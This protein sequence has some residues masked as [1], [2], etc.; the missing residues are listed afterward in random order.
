MFLFQ[1]PWIGMNYAPPVSNNE[2]QY[3]GYPPQPFYQPQYPQYA[4]W[5]SKA[6][7]QF[8]TIH[9][10][11]IKSE[12]LNLLNLPSVQPSQSISP[13]RSLNSNSM[14]SNVT[15]WQFLLEL[16]RNGDHPE[17]IQWTNNE[18][19]FK[20]IDAEAV[21]RLWGERKGKH[22]MN[23]DKLSRALRYY[24]D[25]NIIRKV[26]G[27]KFVYRFVVPS[28]AVGSNADI[29]A[30]SMQRSMA[31][32]SLAPPSVLR[33]QPNFD[34]RFPAS[35]VANRSLTVNNAN[36][37]PS[38]V[39]STCSPGS[40][41]SSSGI[42]S[43]GTST[44][45]LSDVNHQPQQHSGS[46]IGHSSR[47]SST[48]SNQ[49]NRKRK[50]ESQ[51]NC[52]DKIKIESTG[53]FS[54]ADGN[55]G[56]SRRARPKPMPLDLTALSNT[57]TSVSVQNNPIN[58]YNAFN[59]LVAQASPLLQHSPALLNIYA[60]ASLSAA[61][62]S[63][64][65]LASFP[66]AL[67]SPLTLAAMAASPTFNP[68]NNTNNN[69]NLSM[70]GN[71]LSALTTPIIPNRTP[72]PPQSVPQQF[73]EFPPSTQAAAQIAIATMLRSPSLQSPFLSALTG[74]STPNAQSNGTKFNLSPDALKTP[75][76]REV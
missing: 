6:Q 49:T 29:L 64:S 14:D 24:Y 60:A 43:A 57:A 38:P 30:Y 67:A 17:Q 75:V 54:G 50:H 8:A 5:Q 32:N 72:Q 73:F 58:N 26:N 39:N 22:Q 4:N 31:P 59:S 2:H 34:P 62:Q 48:A 69:N 16:L 9:Q 51:P 44:C 61:I 76:I 35:E 40:V 74:F 28:E 71:S 56:L 45:N 10:P 53:P 25:K 7:M 70:F 52:F 55:S 13:N 37:T 41:G 3:Y 19:E 15:L 42:S 20:L 23:Y 21:A 27:Q 63:H 68:I 46:S 18:G 36:S 12:P 47:P 33:P 1:V 65:P 66:A 11:E